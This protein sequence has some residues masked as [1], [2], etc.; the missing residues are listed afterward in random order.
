[1]NKT[2]I[3]NRIVVFVFLLST[4]SY[5][6]TTHTVLVGN[7]GSFSFKPE[8]LTIKSGDT[9][10]WEWQAN[11]HTTTSDRTTGPEVWD[12]G[13][14]NSGA[15]FSKVF[16]EE[17]TYTY[18]CT[19][20]QSF[21][22]VGTITVELALGINNFEDGDIES[23]YLTQN[24]PNPFNPETNI[25]FNVPEESE[26]TLTVFDLKGNKVAIILKDKVSSG[27]HQVT[28]DGRNQLGNHLS[29]GVY[30]YSLEAGN[31]TQTKKMI[32]LK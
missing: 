20:H 19:P 7:G 1:M 10:V 17:G 2:T 28:W 5:S 18:H 29:G 27:F 22:M 23:F 9:V 25:Q 32:F 31:F 15:T 12:S 30:L 8:N 3:S 16:T 11:N 13:I 6:Q 14:R 26:V 24:F 21:G 4:I